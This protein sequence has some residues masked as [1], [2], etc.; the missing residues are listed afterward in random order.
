MDTPT[1]TFMSGGGSGETQAAGSGEVER[2]VYEKERTN[3]VGDV[4]P[5]RSKSDTRSD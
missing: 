4:A 3:G 1:G 2:K 5:S